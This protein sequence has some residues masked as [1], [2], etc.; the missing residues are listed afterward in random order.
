M[1]GPVDDKEQLSVVR[2]AE[3]WRI[4]AAGLWRGRF[5]HQVDAIEAAIR[6]AGDAHCGGHEVAVVVQDRFGRLT[7][8]DPVSYVRRP[9]RQG[10]S[11]RRAW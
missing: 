11:Q 3:G 6:L 5:E 1:G 9:A 4:L 2:F 10:R 8:L 7:D